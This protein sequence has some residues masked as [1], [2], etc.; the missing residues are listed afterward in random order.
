MT[1]LEIL[2][3]KG[4]KVHSIGPDATLLDVAVR[5]VE[6]HCGSL[7]VCDPRMA[8]G[9]VIGIVTERDLLRAAARNEGSLQNLHVR[10]YMTSALVTARPHDSIDDAMGIMTE[11]RIRHLPVMDGDE[12]VGLISIGDVVK[13]QHHQTMQENHYLKSYIQS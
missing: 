13:T 6:N 1:L 12:L 10:D 7:I 9:T 5:L 8:R 2:S 3:V 4:N 11:H